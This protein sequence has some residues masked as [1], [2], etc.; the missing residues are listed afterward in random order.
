M[1]HAPIKY[2]GGKSLMLKKIYD[3][4]PEPSYSVYVEPF[5]GSYSVGLNMS[6]VPSITI[7]NDLNKNVYSLYKV[8]QDEELFNQFK[9]RLDLTP[10]SEDLRY[11]AIDELKRDDLSMVERA[12]WFFVRN[13]LSRNGIGD[14]RSIYS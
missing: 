10:Y 4:F 6:Y 14:F 2:F 13:R 11:E 1:I 7:M 8:I 9:N 3:Q 5:A 12:Y